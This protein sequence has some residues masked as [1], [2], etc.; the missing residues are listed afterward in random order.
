MCAK[1]H[2]HSHSSQGANP[3]IQNIKVARERENAA[4][5]SAQ[6]R[7]ERKGQNFAVSLS[8]HRSAR[9]D[10]GPHEL[11]N[12]RREESLHLGPREPL[13][14]VENLRVC[15]GGGGG[16]GEERNVICLVL[17]YPK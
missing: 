13:H 7:R 4:G 11:V 15:V 16:G 6:T 5:Q 12:T 8:R 17:H 14:L 3:D 9:F 1:I 10:P 2:T